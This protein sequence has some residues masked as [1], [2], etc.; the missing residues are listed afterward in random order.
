MV[1]ILVSIC[2][3]VTFC[4]WFFKKVFKIQIFFILC[5]IN[6]PNF[7]IWLPLLPEISGNMCITIVCCL[8]CDIISYTNYL[9]FLNKPFS[10][11][12]KYS[13][14]QLKYLN[15]DKNFQDKM[16]KI[17][18]GFY[19]T[20]SWQ[21]LSQTWKCGFQM[22]PISV[23]QCSVPNAHES[24]YDAATFLV[25]S[26]WLAFRHNAVGSIKTRKRYIWKCF[27]HGY[28]KNS[29]IFS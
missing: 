12:I 1:S 13:E 11:I 3:G 14:Q 4:T 26:V 8:V 9:N 16:K 10:Y 20:F 18:H 25:I 5:C 23:K 7:I 29:S 6:W 19:G 22:F 27:L 24:N 21:K 2:L 15:N 28:L 17:F